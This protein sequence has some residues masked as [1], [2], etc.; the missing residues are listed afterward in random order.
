[1]SKE[2]GVPVVIEVIV[3]SP[4]FGGS[5]G[6]PFVLTIENVIESVVALMFAETVIEDTPP[7]PGIV[8]V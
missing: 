3:P 8:S 7:P 4:G 6:T 5:A 1:M 2:P